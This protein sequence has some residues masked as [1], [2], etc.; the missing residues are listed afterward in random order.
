MTFLIIVFVGLG[1]FEL[2]R[3]ALALRVGERLR[4]RLHL[5]AGTACAIV[6]GVLI[7]LG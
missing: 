2:I 1:L 5:I 4:G 7:C 3:G 6:S